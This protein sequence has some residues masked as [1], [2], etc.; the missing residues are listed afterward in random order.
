MVFNC[1]LVYEESAITGQIDMI[2]RMTYIYYSR[3]AP[4]SKYKIITLRK[5]SYVINV[6]SYDFEQTILQ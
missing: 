4:I 1:D 5:T 6:L 3:V 2:H